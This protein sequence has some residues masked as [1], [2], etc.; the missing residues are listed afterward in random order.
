MHPV[1][2]VAGFPSPS[3]HASGEGAPSS[4][5]GEP[6]PGQPHA[7]LKSAGTP[8]FCAMVMSAAAVLGYAAPTIMRRR[9]TSSG[10][11]AV[12]DTTPGC[13]GG[14]GRGGRIARWRSHRSESAWQPALSRSAHGRWCSLATSCQAKTLVWSMARAG[15]PRRRA[16]PKTRPPP[17]RGSPPPCPVP[18][19]GPTPPRPVSPSAHQRQR[20]R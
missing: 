3:A 10:K 12:A 4:P 7:P 6:L 14:G 8:S 15:W 19:P 9:A 2:P 16:G 18:P 11:V 13:A 5:R 17:P 20:Q 1:P